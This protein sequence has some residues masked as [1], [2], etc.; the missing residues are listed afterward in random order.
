MINK[1]EGQVTALDLAGYPAEA[2]TSRTILKEKSGTVTFFAFAKGQSLSEHSTSFEAL[3]HILEG[4]A[5]I[6]VGGKA[7]QLATGEILHMPANIPHSVTAV[8]AFKM[9]LVMIRAG[10]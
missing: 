4:R 3:A 7:H 1:I 10:D 2:I 6:T 9:L 5:E 8:E